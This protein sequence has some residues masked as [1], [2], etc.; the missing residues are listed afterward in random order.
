MYS[1]F[2]I[3]PRTGEARPMRLTEEEFICQMAKSMPTGQQV[4]AR[5]SLDV[6]YTEKRRIL[7]ANKEKKASTSKEIGRASCRERV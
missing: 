4:K 1:P 2:K 7:E 6:S 3:N 5:G